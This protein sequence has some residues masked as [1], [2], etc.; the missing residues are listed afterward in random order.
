M[1]HKERMNKNLAYLTLFLFSFAFL[2][3]TVGIIDVVVLILTTEVAPGTDA[4]DMAKLVSLELVNAATILIFSPITA[5][6]GMVIM[7]FNKYRA[8]WY[9]WSCLIFSLPYVALFPLGTM[10]FAVTWFY[11]LLKRQEFKSNIGVNVAIKQ[12]NYRSD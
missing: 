7:L 12:A 6:I 2:S 11:L 9:F 4:K 3:V 1:L 10:I 8:R 5:A